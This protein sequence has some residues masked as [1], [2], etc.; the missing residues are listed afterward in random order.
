MSPSFL[1]ES[2]ARVHADLAAGTYGQGVPAR[3]T[4]TPPSLR[5]SL[6]RE[7]QRGA[8]VVEYKRVSPGAKSPLPPPRSVPEF[9]R[10]TARPGVAGYS[11]LA[12]AHGF[13]GSSARVAE[14]VGQTARPVLFK[15]FVVAPEQL[16]VA[17]R[18]GA[19]AVLLIA[20]LATQR[21]LDA[22]LEELSEE[23]HR[24]GLEVLLELHEPAELSQA[25]GVAADVYGVNTRDLATLELD[26]PAAFATLE[27]ARRRG[28]APLMGLS[29]VESAADAHE[30]WSRGCDGL[31][32]GS[33]V[34]R[35]S[36]VGA[37]LGSLRRPESEARR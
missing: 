4:V 15:E 22:P 34:A 3:R 20:R 7:R 6:E 12:S 21:L 23:A 18:T 26:R 14:L 37:L 30:F 31:L 17:E 27:A 28:L 2:V 33:A 32:I 10:L 11:C 29:G 16:A 36:D 8:L 35:T 13:D 9:L 25:D 1:E 24:R 5:Q 19:A